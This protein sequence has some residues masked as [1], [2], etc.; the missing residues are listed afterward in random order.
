[1][2]KMVMAVSSR[3]I[4]ITYRCYYLP[5]RGKKCP[6][7][8]TNECLRCRYCRAEMSA[9]DATRLM[10]AYRGTAKELQEGNEK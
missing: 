8:N 2:G 7:K 3:G 1:M 9:Y 5:D 6:D 4:G 10:S